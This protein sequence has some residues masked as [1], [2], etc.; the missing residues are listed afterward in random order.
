MA[1]VVKTI[2]ASGGDYSLLSAWEADIPADLV[3]V[4]ESWIAE[5][6]NDWPDGLLD[7]VTIANITTSQT[8]SIV[9]TS[10]PSERHDGTPGAGFRVINSSPPTNVDGT[11]VVNVPY[12]TVEYLEVI[13]NN[14]DTVEP[15]QYAISLE[16]NSG[17]G[18]VL[19]SHCIF[20]NSV[21]STNSIANRSVNPNISLFIFCCIGADTNLA[22]YGSIGLSESNISYY[23]CAALISDAGA[24]GFRG[25]R[26]NTAAIYEV[27][28]NI[29]IG[30][31]PDYITDTNDR[32]SS[33][34][35]TSK[36]T[37]DP[38][39]GDVVNVGSA[40]FVDLANRNL[41][42]AAGSQ[43][44]GAGLNLIEAGILTSPQYDLD[45]N[46]W[47]DTGPWDIGPYM[48]AD[49]EPPPSGGSVMIGDTAASAIMAGD[50]AVDKIMIGDNQIWP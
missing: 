29:A 42:L 4:D 7:K 12:V 50:T 35:S 17:S 36:S 19:V 22:V 18:S 6:Y 15:N 13:N 24:S 39:Y 8:N 23:N 48:Y 30:D 44:I 43:L 27:Y 9:I 33:N 37:L 21:D 2:R 11:I 49:S 25:T 1:D 14:D 16:I 45:G 26:G 47:P 20:N 40:D 46:Q 34:N 41:R 31:G 32:Q 5:C 10:P 3:A 28:N 38:S